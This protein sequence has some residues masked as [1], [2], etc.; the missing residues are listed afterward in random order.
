MF[1]LAALFSIA[2]TFVVKNS[3]SA[4]GSRPALEVA[5]ATKEKTESAKPTRSEP[6]PTVERASAEPPKSPPMARVSEPKTRPKTL[7]MDELQALNAKKQSLPGPGD[8][9]RPGPAAA[10]NG[11][12][13]LFPGPNPILPGAKP[14]AGGRNPMA[15]V[16]DPVPRI[17]DPLARRRNR[18]RGMRQGMAAF[19][20]GQ[21]RSPFGPL[22]N[23]PV[24]DGQPAT[25]GENDI[26]TRDLLTGALLSADKRWH[27]RRRYYLPLVGPDIESA[28]RQL[29]GVEPVIEL[30]WWFPRRVEIRE[31]H[32]KGKIAKLR[33]LTPIN[34]Q[35]L[36]AAEHQ[37]RVI[38]TRG[39]NPRGF[40]L[41]EVEAIFYLWQS[42]RNHRIVQWRLLPTEVQEK[43][44]WFRNDKLTIKR[45]D[46]GPLP[47]KGAE[48]EAV[49][50]A[51]REFEE[52]GDIREVKWWPA[53]VNPEDGHPTSK[54]RYEVIRK[55]DVELGEFVFDHKL[56]TIAY[57][58]LADEV[59]P[60]DDRHATSLEPAQKEGRRDLGFPEIDRISE[61]RA[62]RAR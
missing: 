41:V 19:R 16:P 44:E 52:D 13:P 46:I 1:L 34:E 14:G 10:L 54:L 42:D 35:Q 32:Y 57:S 51:V 59:F 39:S 43:P 26:Y 48:I 17:K 4:V 8:E 30:Q 61:P 47:V 15:H 49:R 21:L 24:V 60:E 40:L 38:A 6:D 23:R 56:Q 18:V 20:N 33:F 25:D 12:N 50:K 36:P 11:A 7:P 9:P 31:Q 53:R 22:A 3:L 29:I 2:L 62:V 45:G 37:V 27:V 5:K 55:G 28:R 58:R